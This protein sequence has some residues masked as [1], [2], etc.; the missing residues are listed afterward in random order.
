MM[1]V[2]NIRELATLAWQYG[3]NNT[4]VAPLAKT[5]FDWQKDVKRLAL[6]YLY[7]FSDTSKYNEQEILEAY[8][9]IEA[10]EV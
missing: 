5:I 7:L 10:M 2:N 8:N 4:K 3:M 1:N 9:G 6:E